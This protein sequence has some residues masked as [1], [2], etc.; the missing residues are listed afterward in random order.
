VLAQVWAG[1]L[2]GLYNDSFNSAQTPVDWKRT[3]IVTILKPGKDPALADSYRP[4]SLLSCIRKFFERMLLLRLEL[5][6][7]KSG[8]LSGTQFGLRKGKGTT[9]CL[10]VLKNQVLVAFLDITGAYENVLIDILCRELKK[11]GV[12]VLLVFFLWD[13]MW[14]KHLY[15]FFF[16]SGRGIYAHGL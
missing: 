1:V 16:W 14:E 4:I 5:W 12:P 8:I 13:M 11:E 3:R 10:A 9:D 6:A 15:F 2:L 7:E